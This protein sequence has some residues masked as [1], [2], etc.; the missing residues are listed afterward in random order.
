[1]IRRLPRRRRYRRRRRRRTVA[2]SRITAAPAPVA[3]P[4]P[5]PTFAFVAATEPG[6][7]SCAS[8]SVTFDARLGGA[9]RAETGRAGPGARTRATG[10]SGSERRVQIPAL[11]V[12]TRVVR[13]LPR[14][15]V[16]R[17]MVARGSVARVARVAMVARRVW[18]P[19]SRRVWRRA[20]RVSRALRRRGRVAPRR[21]RRRV[22]RRVRAPVKIRSCARARVPRRS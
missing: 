16:A 8:T 2:A 12:E 22:A 19:R 4:D 13:T 15:R 9:R 5:P 10:D 14:R 17:E 11:G 6:R 21:R 20:A 3:T 18:R 7:F 1:M